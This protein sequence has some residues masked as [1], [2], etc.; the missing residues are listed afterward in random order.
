MNREGTLDPMVAREL[1][2]R[3]VSVDGI[4]W[5]MTV[6]WERISDRDVT[7][8]TFRRKNETEIDRV[9]EIPPDRVLYVLDHPSLT[10][11]AAPVPVH[12]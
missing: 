5:V 2:S 11:Y 6:L 12:S 10:Y 4:D 7:F 9:V 8:A 3:V 1:D